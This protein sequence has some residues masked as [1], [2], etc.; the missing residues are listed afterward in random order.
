MPDL[1]TE[2]FYHCKSAEEWEINVSNSSETGVYRVKYG[3]KHLNPSVRNDYSCNCKA[4]LYGKGKHCKHIIKWKGHHC[5]WMQF[6]DG[7][8]LRYN[9]CPECGGE[10]NSRGWQT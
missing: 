10:V 1:N 6:F 7:G 9:R 4:Y 5:N 3:K 8:K 2:Y